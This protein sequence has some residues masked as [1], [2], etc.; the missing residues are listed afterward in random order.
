[1]TWATA[2]SAIFQQA[3]LSTIAGLV[4]STTPPTSMTGTGLLGDTVNVSLFNN[5]TAPDK[6]VA[7]AS[8]LY[9]TGVWGTGN[10][11]IDTG[12]TNWVAGGRP[13]AS[14]TWALDTGSS[15]LCFHAANTAGAG[16]VTITNAY[17]CLVYDGT[18]TGTYVKQGLCFNYFGGAQSVSAG[19]FT[20]IWATAGATTAVFNITV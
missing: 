17:G 14:K 13:L 4:Q 15:S 3:M 11:V 1:M 10:E 20:I 5:T 19:T 7:L 9:N 6:T 18:L 8:S 16:N 2:G 12:G